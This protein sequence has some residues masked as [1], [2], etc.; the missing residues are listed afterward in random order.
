[1][2][3]FLYI[4]VFISLHTYGQEV[5]GYLYDSNGRIQNNI[6]LENI[7][8]QL[9]S[10]SDENGFFKITANIQDTIVF[11]SILYEEYRLVINRKHLDDNIVIELKNTTL[12]EVRILNNKK[13]P[14]EKLDEKLY[15]SLRQD[16]IKNPTFYEPHKGNIIYLLQAARGLLM[17]KKEV[18]KTDAPISKMMNFDDFRILFAK[19]D[20]LNKKFLSEN[21]SIPERY[22]PLFFEF[23][24]SKKIDSNLLQEK[25]KL[26]LI[27][28]VYNAGKEYR[29]INQLSN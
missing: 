24:V 18:S 29:E 4:L 26:D 23:L 6:T 12:E 2:R 14:I 16:I 10:T 3:I 21:L 15:Y 19:D 17:R 25:K 5:Q 27:D 28:L 22:H 9:N 13:I 20:I 1:M 8:Q 11:N 7:T